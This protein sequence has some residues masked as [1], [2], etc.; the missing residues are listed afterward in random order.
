M[1]KRLDLRNFK[2]WREADLTFGRVTGLFGANSS[3]KSSLAQFLLLLKQTAESSDR[4]AA[5]S[6]NGPLRPARRRDG[7]GPCA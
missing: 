4:A 1:L 5:L 6:L 3:G 2:N 7:R